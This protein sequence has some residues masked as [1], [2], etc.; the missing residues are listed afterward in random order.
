M[1][2]DLMPSLFVE[3]LKKRKVDWILA[4]FF[5]LLFGILEITT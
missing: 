5:T 4:L 2:Q 1:L 3:E